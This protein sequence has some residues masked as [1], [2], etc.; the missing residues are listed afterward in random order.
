MVIWNWIFLKRKL[1][2][3]QHKSLKQFRVRDFNECVLSGPYWSTRA[4]KPTH[5]SLK[6]NLMADLMRPY[7]TFGQILCPI[8]MTFKVSLKAEKMSHICRHIWWHLTTFKETL[9]VI[10]RW[11]LR[12]PKVTYMW[13]IWRHTCDIYM[14]FKVTLKVTLQYCL[15]HI[16][17]NIYVDIYVT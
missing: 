10:T 12:K 13:H 8:S 5:R 14:T 1:A 15:C 6:K 9:K 7:E 16:N 3:E 2:Q 17:V 11:T 4:N